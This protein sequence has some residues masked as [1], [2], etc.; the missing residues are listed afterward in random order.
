MSIRNFL[1]NA[2]FGAALAAATVTGARAQ[3]AP[4][5]DAVVNSATLQAGH[6]PA[7]G[8]M[9]IYGAGLSDCATVLNTLPTSMNCTAADGVRLP[10]RSSS[11]TARFMPGN[12][13]VTGVKNR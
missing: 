10:R 11:R 1:R 6:V 12:H 5:I 8:W 13:G 4:S 9:T 7:D 3:T 2:T